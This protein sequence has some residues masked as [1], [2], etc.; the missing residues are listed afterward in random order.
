M[1]LLRFLPRLR[2]WYC[3]FPPHQGYNGPRCAPNGSD[4]SLRAVQNSFAP[5]QNPH[6]ALLCGFCVWS[7]AASGDTV[8]AGKEGVAVGKEV[9][10]REGLDQ[11]R[12]G[13]KTKKPK[14]PKKGSKELRKIAT[15]A[16][17][18]M[19]I[20]ALSASA[21]MA[22]TIVGNPWSETLTGTAQSDTISGKEGGDALIGKGGNDFL[23]GNRGHDGLYGGPGDDEIQG[24]P[25]DDRAEERSVH[26]GEG[27]DI[28]YGDAGGGAPPPGARHDTPPPGGGP[29]SALGVG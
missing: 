19:L 20:L 13:S 24:G 28:L 14:K 5:T 7:A 26:G 6:T 1:L 22:A 9:V 16:T 17:T 15:I 12:P 10:G 23:Y 2:F 27:A 11:H 18:I 21:A 25:G 3:A 4:C 8:G 29:N